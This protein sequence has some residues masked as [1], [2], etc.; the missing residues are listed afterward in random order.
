MIWPASRASSIRC[1][2]AWGVGRSRD[3]AH[4]GDLGY[5]QRDPE[6]CISKYFTLWPVE[7]PDASWA[8]SSE[9]TYSSHPFMGCGYGSVSGHPLLS[10]DGGSSLIWGKQE[11]LLERME[12]ESSFYQE[13]FFHW[14]PG[15]RG[16]TLFSAVCYVKRSTFVS[17]F[18]FQNA[19]LVSSIEELKTPNWTRPISTRNLPLQ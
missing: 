10:A 3:G 13:N 1:L 9:I 16:Q 5:R 19:F 8:A 14:I 11:V 4:G 15:H 2:T 18:F 7:L 12:L 6:A 17:L